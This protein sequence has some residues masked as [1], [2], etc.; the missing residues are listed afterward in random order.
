VASRLPANRI[1]TSVT[2]G[3]SRN[4]FPYMALEY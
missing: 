3:T 4:P 1:A 2:L